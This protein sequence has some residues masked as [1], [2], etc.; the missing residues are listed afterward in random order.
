MAKSLVIVE[1][2]AKAKTINKFLG[3]GYIV[4]ASGGHVL[5]LPEHK[6]L[7][8]ARAGD[9][10]L[11]AATTT[12]LYASTDGKTWQPKAGAGLSLEAVVVSP[13]G[14]IF[15]GGEQGLYEIA[16][17]E[18]KRLIEFPTVHTLAWHQDRLYAGSEGGLWRIT[19]KED[20]SQ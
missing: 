5:D 13:E 16:D 12:G 3:S 18:L 8:L 9:G 17:D 14:R 10:V 11:Y 7:A 1:S 20:F 6:A 2:P 19:W 15:A 4:K